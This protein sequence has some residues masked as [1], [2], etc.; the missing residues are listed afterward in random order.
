MK[1]HCN[2]PKD[3]LRQTF[4]IS[5]LVSFF[6]LP[7][8][9]PNLS[10]RDVTFTWTA[11]PETVESYKLY[12]KTGSSG[13][14]YNGVGATEGASP[15]ST[16]NVTTYT[17]HNLSDTETYYFALTAYLSGAESAYSEELVLPPSGV[18]RLISIKEIK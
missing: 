13:E 6:F 11:N 18:P 7:L 5:I 4:Y 14:D 2:P 10:A 16:G 1:L 8:N 15:V 3:T 17:L 9:P 12:Y